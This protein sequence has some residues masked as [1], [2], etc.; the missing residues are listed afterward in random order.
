LV[1]ALLAAIAGLYALS[2]VGL[3]R[4]LPQ[5]RTG[6]RVS[7]SLCTL[8][9][10]AFVWFLLAMLGILPNQEPVPATVWQSSLVFLLIGLPYLVG[11]VYGWRSLSQPAAKAD[12]L[13]PAR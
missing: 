12:R 6:L 5:Q 10:I 9:G 2:G 4:R 13:A 8:R 11:L 3:L 7:G 1:V